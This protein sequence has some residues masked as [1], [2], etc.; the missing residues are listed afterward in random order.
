MTVTL[1]L[2]KSPRHGGGFDGV[3]RVRGRNEQARIPRINLAIGTSKD[4]YSRFLSSFSVGC[5]IS[6]GGDEYSKVM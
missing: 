2:L 6:L 5:G 4:T 1:R 3:A